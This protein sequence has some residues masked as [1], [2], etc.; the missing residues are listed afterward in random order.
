MAD[1]LIYIAD[2]Q[3]LTREGVISFLTRYFIGEAVIEVIGYRDGLLSKV[4]ERPPFLIIIDHS[5]FDWTSPDDYIEL[6]KIAVDSAILVIS[7]VLTYAQ[8]RDVI[9]AGISYFLLKTSTEEDFFTAFKSIVN[10]RKYIS[11]E[12][13]DLMIQRDKSII[14]NTVIVK[15]SPSEIEIA[16]L[17][18]EGKTTKEIANYKHLS[19]HTINTHRK[20]IFRKLGI[21]TS[22]ELVKYIYNSGLSSDI[23]YHI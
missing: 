1:K 16:R 8:A 12:I 5:N 10:K 23:E 18:A 20:N 15:L 11:S 2:N 6:K 14:Q 21:N 17:I 3:D 19:F 7:E 4:K 9:N 22:N 13:Y